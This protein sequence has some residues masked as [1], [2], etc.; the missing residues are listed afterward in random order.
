MCY[1][2]YSFL[3]ALALLFAGCKTD[4][5]PGDKM[6]SNGQDV[7]KT[8]APEPLGYPFGYDI[9]TFALDSMHEYEAG[10]CSGVVRQL[11]NDGTSILIDS[12]NCGDYGYSCKYLV[13]DSKTLLYAHSIQNNYLGATEDD[14]PIFEYSQ[15]IY[16]F[17]SQPAR[18][19]Y[20]VDTL[21]SL[22][23]SPVSNKSYI[24]TEVP[25]SEAIAK[26]ILEDFD[27]SW[28]W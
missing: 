12:T 2:T 21:A 7:A 3:F 13:R 4:S 8:R 24:P 9:A 10:D 11:S 5:S 15:N 1:N 23:Y 20:R 28:T 18:A 26:G 19:F 17:T 27:R 6:P 25:D 16:D 22:V 14:S